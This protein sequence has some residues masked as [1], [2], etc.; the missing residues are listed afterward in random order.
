M[1]R[2]ITALFTAEISRGGV[3][4]VRVCVCVCVCLCV[5]SADN[6]CVEI[7][8]CGCFY[9]GHELPAGA[10][11]QIQCQQWSVSYAASLLTISTAPSLLRPP[12]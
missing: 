3:V 1:I 11:V 5:S 10:V 9:R 8:Q 6:T 12:L 2:F 7:S 4:Y